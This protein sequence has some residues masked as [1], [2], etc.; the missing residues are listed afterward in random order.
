VP[1]PKGDLV[2]VGFLSRHC[3]AGL[4]ILTF[5]PGLVCRKD[6]WSDGTG[7][8]SDLPA[9]P[10]RFQ[11]CLTTK[12]RPLTLRLSAAGGSRLYS[13]A[14]LSCGRNPGAHRSLWVALG[15]FCCALIVCAGVAQVGH[16]HSDG[17][18]VQ[19]D[20]ALCHTVHVAVQP[21]I[22]QTW[23]PPVRIVGK[24]PTAVDPLRLRHF[25]LFTLFSRPPPV[26]VA[27]A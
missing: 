15:F 16:F 4:W 22:P 12:P 13:L 17:Q 1:S 5:L 6:L 11:S 9:L 23:A 26:D 27:F 14:M 7:S 20:C 25:S 8:L 19:S 24:I 21:L 2:S 3:R 18:S 10:R